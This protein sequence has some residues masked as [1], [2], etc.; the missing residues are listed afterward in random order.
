MIMSFFR[1]ICLIALFVAAC[2]CSWLEDPTEGLSSDIAGQ[3]FC[4]S[5]RWM[6][7]EPVDLN[8]DSVSGN[9]LF[10]E[11]SGLDVASGALNN[12]VIKVVRVND[13][14]AWSDRFF[15]WFPLQGLDYDSADGS[16]DLGCTAQY[17]VFGFSYAIGGDGDI[18]VSNPVPLGIFP[19]AELLPDC[20]DIK[21]VKMGDNRLIVDVRT[22][23]YDFRTRTVVCGLVKYKY[24]RAFDGP[25]RMD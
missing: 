15:V 23:F 16:Y 3:Y 21:V 14:D 6:E 9:D 5:A 19:K 4:T 7:T 18:S 17:E 24:E 1:H 25:Y 22:S 10:E 2:S 8:G 12:S 11:F 20:G 13:F